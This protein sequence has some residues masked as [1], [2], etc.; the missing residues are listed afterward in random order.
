MTIKI[1][2]TNT[3]A[4]PS[5]TGTDTDTGLV[6]GTGEV[7]VVTDGTERLKVDSS[8]KVGIGTSSPIGKLT[9]ADTTANTIWMTGRSAD[10]TSSIS[11]RNN[12]DSAYIAR[13]AADNS[14]ALQFRGASSEAMRID[15]SGRL[16][17]GTSSNT[18]DYRFQLASSSYKGALF[19]RHGSDGVEVAL[20]S[21]RG[22]QGSKTALNNN[23]YGGL[24]TF[25]GYDGSNYQRLAWI[26]G[27]CDGQS[28]ASGDSPGRLV[29]ST[30]ADG[31][32]SPTERMRINSA[33]NI[34]FNF[35]GSTATGASFF[36]DGTAASP[37]LGFWA[38]GSSD[39]GIFRPGSNILGF[40]TGATEAMRIDSS[41]RVGIGTSSPSQKLHVVASSG[42]N[43]CVRAELSGTATYQT[44]A[45]YFVNTDTGTGSARGIYTSGT[46]FGVYSNSGVNFFGGNV[47]IGN[48]TPG[49]ALEVHDA[50][51]GVIVAKQTTNNGGFNTFV[52]E[53]SSGNTKFYVTHNG[54]VGASGGIIFGSDT[55][56]ANA[57]DDYE[58]GTWIPGLYVNSGTHPTLTITSNYSSYTKVGKLVTF[59]ADFVATISSVGSGSGLRISLPFVPSVSVGR[60]VYSGGPQGRASTGL[61]LPSYEMSW[62]YYTDGARLYQES[63]NGV[64]TNLSPSYINSGGGK[65]FNIG[66]F[67][68]VD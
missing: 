45:G 35:N 12:A 33:G 4:N 2:G 53:D 66:G 39:T 49:H 60:T 37:G 3:V 31:A 36:A 42:V 54:R 1:N 44:D 57:L 43:N 51:S 23:D 48:L 47:G 27:V 8:G 56:A 22:T 64:E 17:V 58:E 68:Y 61:T 16:L 41:G 25:K 21:A 28:P 10:D 13:I 18:D 15:S 55:A 6:Y 11:F 59:S 19:T 7:S 38:D 65:R 20:G 34:L 52:G 62:F 9:I 40:T 30:T 67:Y 50:S 14:G 32:S 26:G 29:F 24:V 46:D 5:I 63:A